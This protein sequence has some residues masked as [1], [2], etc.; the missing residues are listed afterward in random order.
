MKLIFLAI[1]VIGLAPTGA[2]AADAGM[3]KTE[4]DK[5]NY[6]IGVDIARNIKRQGV[7]VEVEVLLKGMR[8]TLTGNQL[9]MTE[10]ELRS[11]LA[12]FQADQ[13]KRILQARLTPNRIAQLNNEEGGIFLATN[14]TR[15][16][17]TTLSSG[18]QYQILRAGQGRKPKATD[19]VECH[20]RGTLVNGTVF[21]DS[22]QRKKPVTL[23]LSEAL[24]G[25]QEALPLM[26]VGSKWQL[27]VPAAL[28]Y[29][30]QGSTNPP[31]GP[32]ATL[33]FE[34]ELLAIK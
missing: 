30:P 33:L 25:W 3:L 11:T 14:K 10:P 22:Y 23:R 31:I 1:L 15:P 20:Y 7:E 29:G 12:V 16:G 9:L 27:F 26:A 34:L 18:L 6:G 19:T 5:L 24:P 8:D 21:D 13:K 32:N 17:V 28:A 2:N 4:K